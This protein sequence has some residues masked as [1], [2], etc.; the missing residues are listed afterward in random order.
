MKNFFEIGKNSN[1]ITD[2][3]VIV[4]YNIY[5]M[6]IREEVFCIIRAAIFLFF[7]GY[8]FFNSFVVAIVM[9]LL[10]IIYPKYKKTE[11]IKKRKEELALQFKDALYSISSSLSAG[12][13]LE[14][15]FKSA[16]NELRIIYPE[17]KTL[18]IREFEYMCRKLDL[19]VPVEIVF[20]EFAKRA[21]QE[22]IKN[23]A[24]VIFVCKKA[25]GNLV[26][27]TKNTATIIRE[28]IEIKQDIN[29]LLARQKYE[30]KILNI[31]PIVFIV[32]LKYGGYGYL[33]TL[34]NS[35]MGNV[36]L[37]LALIILVCSYL[38][39]QSIINI[40]V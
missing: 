9:A 6:S 5:A 26:H 12:K 13:S 8:L 31:M 4:N 24:D 17:S 25:G 34:Y 29:S 16:L 22:D 7:I 35:L 1:Y 39:S 10:S 19:G 36:L 3:K 38:W 27:V 37:G 23:F 14:N 40:R 30:Q 21:D 15:C 11:L 32:L 28:K 20:Q 2:S 18:I 33:D